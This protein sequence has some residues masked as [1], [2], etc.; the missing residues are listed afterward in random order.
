MINMFIPFS[1][2]INS[3]KYLT[4]IILGVFAHSEPDHKQIIKASA[5]LEV[6]IF[7]MSVSL[8]H[9]WSAA[10]RAVASNGNNKDPF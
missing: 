1:R 7:P 9:I 8:K 2:F 4:K 6:F 5:F 10:P 3:K